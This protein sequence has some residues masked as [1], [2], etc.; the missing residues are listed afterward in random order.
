[1]V[2]AISSEGV[3]QMNDSSSSSTK[4][5]DKRPRTGRRGVVKGLAVGVGGVTLSHWS[6][7][8]VKAVA[9]PAHAQTSG[10]QI[11]QRASVAG[12]VGA[13]S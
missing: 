12:I 6:E 2:P 13:Y 8:I 5:S 10:F 7:P 1:M 11:T 3:Q 9:L 4:T